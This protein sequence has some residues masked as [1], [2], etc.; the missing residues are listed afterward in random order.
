MATTPEIFQQSFLVEKKH[1]DEQNHVNNVQ[2]V[3]WVQDVARAH[4]EARATKEQ[5]DKLKRPRKFMQSLLI[6]NGRESA[7]LHSFRHT[8][9]Q[10]LFDLGLDIS[11]R[12]KLLAHASSDTTKVYTHPN[13]DL[14][15]QYV[16]RI[17]LY[18]KVS[19]N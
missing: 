14:A 17:P 5:N 3:Q 10:T 2:Y 13:F 15:S 18:N 16:N 9:N 4:W 11:D 19:G 1:L 7:T 12:Q 6:A 8:F